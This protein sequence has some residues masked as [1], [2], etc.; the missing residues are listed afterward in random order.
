MNECFLR[1]ARVR[2]AIEHVDAYFDREIPADGMLLCMLRAGKVVEEA[3]EAYQELITY[4]GG[5]PRKGF[6]HSPHQLLTE[7]A[8]TAL[9]AVLGMQHILKDMN[10]VEEYLSVALKLAVER[11]GTDFVI[12]EPK[13]IL[14]RAGIRVI[15]V[16]YERASDGPIPWHGPVPVRCHH[17]VDWP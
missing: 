2:S 7:L 16:S 1:G 3:G 9:S 17:G 5:N 8:Q 12:H 10:E 15:Q 6:D 4:A 13:Q 11:T 14:C